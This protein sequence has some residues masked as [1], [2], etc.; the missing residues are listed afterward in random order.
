MIWN[1][2]LSSE[3]VLEHYKRGALDL[4]VEVRSCD[5]PKCGGEEFIGHYI[6]QGVNS[7]DVP[8][9]RYF[10]YRV[11]FGTEDDIYSPEL[12]DVKVGYT[13]S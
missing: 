3:E 9:N 8:K 4:Y 5:D 11:N 1:R 12:E 7:I 6:K 13:V 2:I 10:Q